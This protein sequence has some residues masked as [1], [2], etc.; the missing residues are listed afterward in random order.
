MQYEVTIGI[1][2]Y[3]VEKYIRQTM[4]SV[5]AQTFESI[6]F[7][8]CDDCGSDSSIDIIR[9]YQRDHP[10][11]KDIRI[12]RQPYNKGV[13]EARNMII[14]EVRSRY[15]FFMDADDTITPNAIELLYNNAIRYNAQIVY[16]SY[17]RIQQMEDNV[18]IPFH[19]PNLQFFEENEFANYVYRSYDVIQANTW[20][21]LVEINVYRNNN[22]KYLPINFWEDFTFTMDLPTYISRAV[23]ISDITY[24]YY[25]RYGTLSNYQKR[26]SIEK[27][28]I[29]KT[30]HSL[31]IIKRN[32]DRIADKPYFTKR[33]EKVMLTCFYMACNII[34]HRDIINPLF[35]DKEIRN[36]LRSPLSLRKTLMMTPK[37][38]KCLFLFVLEILSPALSVYIIKKLG[39][40]KGII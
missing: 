2:V 18:I 12:I 29:I 24:S 17:E 19:Y 6:E 38:I 32:S 22:L 30:I 10:R 5:M 31:D 14:S 34:K 11:G 7:L 40:F 28:E 25:C 27:N 16:G 26:D 20:N 4:D 15:V 9:E 1:P 39:K 13:G 3:N 36:I 21:F 23:L 33:M 35:S 37:S 8:I